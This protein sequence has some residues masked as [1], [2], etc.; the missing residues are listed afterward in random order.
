[1]WWYAIQCYAVQQGNISQSDDGPSPLLDG[2]VSYWTLDEGLGTRVDSQG[3]NNLTDNNTVGSAA[4][5]ISNAASF[6]AAN[7]EYLSSTSTALQMGTNDYAV[8]FWLKTSSALQMTPLYNG[9]YRETGW[10]IATLSGGNLFLK[11][12][13]IPFP[14]GTPPNGSSV[15]SYADGNWH[16]VVVNFDRDSNVSM[17]VDGNTTPVIAFDI[18]GYA[19]NVAPFRPFLVGAYE[20]GLGRSFFFDGLIDEIGIWGRILTLTEISDLYNSGVGLTYPF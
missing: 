20:D 18:S 7:T 16:H 10:Y 13:D 8:S 4:G 12:S 5:K 3:S 6:V 15:G 1:M 19:G 9:A 2:L 14:S 11:F 17:Y